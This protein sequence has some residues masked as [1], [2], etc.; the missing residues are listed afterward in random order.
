MIG[1]D[2]ARLTKIK[3][4]NVTMQENKRFAQIEKG[5]TSPESS[6]T[7]VEKVTQKAVM[8]V[9]RVQAVWNTLAKAVG[10]LEERGFL[11]SRR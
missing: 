7:P 8:N 10:H 1:T 3:Y 9:S 2:Q 4:E 5:S 6:N 11:L